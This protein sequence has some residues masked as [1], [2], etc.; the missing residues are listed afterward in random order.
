MIKFKCQYSRKEG[1][2]FY[3]FQQA[4]LRWNCTAMDTIYLSSKILDVSIHASELGK[5]KN[6]KEE[7]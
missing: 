4:D 5:Q 3:H 2:L 7:S 6:K 1:N